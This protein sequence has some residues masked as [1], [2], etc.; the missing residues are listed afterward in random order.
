MKTAV[1]GTRDWLAANNEA[2][3]NTV[4]AGTT[5]SNGTHTRNAAQ[6][7]TNADHHSA[8]PEA[9]RNGV[10]TGV[11]A[12]TDWKSV[13]TFARSARKRERVSPVG[14]P[15]TVVPGYS[16]TPMV[17]TSA[18]SDTAP[19]AATDQPARR[20]I[21]DTAWAT[22]ANA[23]SRG[24]KLPSSKSRLKLST[25]DSDST[26][27]EASAYGNSGRTARVIGTPPPSRRDA[28]RSSTR[29]RTADRGSR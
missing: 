11:G 16:T 15:S 7:A 1:S 23:A 9:R 27:R 5:D 10:V 6:S 17:S 12:V 2:N 21:I 14:I 22:S 8:S 24:K 3:T 20:V 19:P 13:H 28:A 29:R 4:P 18:T 25:T 26:T